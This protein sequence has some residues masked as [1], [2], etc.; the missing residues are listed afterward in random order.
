MNIAQSVPNSFSCT[1]THETIEYKNPERQRPEM[2][3]T[4]ATND[5][6]ALHQH[7]T[8]TQ[9]SNRHRVSSTLT[10]AQRKLIPLATRLDLGAANRTEHRRGIEYFLRGDGDGFASCAY[11][12]GGTLAIVYDNRELLRKRGIMEAALV[13]GYSQGKGTHHN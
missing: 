11:S 7:M 10:A 13:G 1:L 4:V 5:H 9:R 12:V 2:L 3:S 8:T 6:H